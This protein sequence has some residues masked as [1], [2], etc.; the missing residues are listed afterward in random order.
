MSETTHLTGNAKR[1][2]MVFIHGAGDWPDGYWNDIIN[3]PEFTHLDFTPIGVRYCQVLQTDQSKAARVSQDAKS[4]QD[5]FVNL[6]ARERLLLEMS[7]RSANLPSHWPALFNP[8][9]LPNL[10]IDPQKAI[11]SL[12]SQMLFGIDFVRLI[13]QITH[14]Q[15]PNG[16]GM[17]TVAQDVFLY[18]YNAV[19]ARKVRDQ[20]VVGLTQAQEYDQVILVSHSLGTVI[21]FDVLLQNT[22]FIPKISHW[23]TLG[24]PIHKVMHLRPMPLPAP[25]PHAQIPNWFN[26]YDS[27]DI[28]AS[29]L[30]PAVDISGCFVHDIFV[31]VGNGM[32]QAHDYFGNAASRTLIANTLR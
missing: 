16:I 7:A 30:G 18:L 12:L 8:A 24:C 25:L 11:L 29:A 6:I 15:F 26:L 21:A 17:P 14:T 23:L 22:E 9:N 1:Q 5:N 20:L 31:K 10:T 32:P 28:I 27:A 2:A 19:I 13:D 3:K 4:F